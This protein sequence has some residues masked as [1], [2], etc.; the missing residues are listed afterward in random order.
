MPS[1][2]E[3]NYETGTIFTGQEYVITTAMLRGHG[4]FQNITHHNSHC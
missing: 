2:N 4:K 1:I 3:N